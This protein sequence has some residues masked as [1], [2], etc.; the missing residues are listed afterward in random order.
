MADAALL[1]KSRN[2]EDRKKAVKML[3]KR[4]DEASLKVL[5]QIYKTDS[6]ADVRDLAQKSA[7]YVLAKLKEAKESGGATDSGGGSAS[8]FTAD[9]AVVVPKKVKVTE[10]DIERAKSF[11]AEALDH[12]MRGDNAKAIKA[13]ERA[14]RTNPNL[15]TDAYFKSVASSVT[16]LDGEA[17]VET[18]MVGEKRQEILEAEKDQARSAAQKEH[19]KNAEKVTWSAVGFDVVVLTVVLLV[20]TIISGFVVKQLAA[21][22]SNALGPQI[23]AAL[24]AD[25]VN[26]EEVAR[27]SVEQEI[28]AG[29]FTVLS[30]PLVLA[31]SFGLWL[32][33]V[34]SLYAQAFFI[35]LVAVN[36]F[37]GAGTMPFLFN[38]LTTL[39]SSRIPI[40]F[41]IVI[42]GAVFAFV[43]G[44]PS[45]I[46]GQIAG[47]AIGLVN[48]VISLQAIARV[49]SA[50]NFGFLMG[51]FTT[52]VA[53]IPYS[54]VTGIIFGIIGFILSIVFSAAFS[55][56]DPTT[57]Q[58]GAF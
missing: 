8:P 20:G 35:H 52:L 25:E 38:R 10:K 24:A 41:G 4:Q 11:T 17:A 46:I 56:L 54:I 28:A 12:N 16:E 21:T 2:P 57:F 49:G 13:L 37:K 47:G 7:R 31:G 1:L 22:R 27:L 3:A 19:L 50:Y 40:I 58:G 15:K 42:L 30:V 39:Y 23:E 48:L 9:P 34:I 36:L 43:A 14:L 55:Q 45:L 29:V 53:S 32:T 18:L 51:C 33:T 44:A 5:A 6:D 26:S